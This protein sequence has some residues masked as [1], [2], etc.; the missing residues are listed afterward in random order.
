MIFYLSSPRNLV[1]D[2]FTGQV[3]PAEAL[4]AMTYLT[5][6]SVLATV[7]AIFWVNTSG[8]DSESVAKQISNIGMHIPGY[9]SDKHSMKQ[10]LDKYIPNL[11]VIGGFIIG[12][13]AALADFTGAIGTGT[14]ILLAVM[15]IYNYY[16]ELSNQDLEGAHPLVKKF[17]GE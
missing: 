13:I 3:V 15:I 8:M 2:I 11:A 12:L 17:L 9:R 16:E 14:G 6:L 10:V 5:F 4:R 1:G 7:F